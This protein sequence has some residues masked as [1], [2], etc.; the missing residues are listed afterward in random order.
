MNP[1]HKP[2]LFIVDDE[3]DQVFLCELA[4]QRTGDFGRIQ[5]AIDSQ[6]AYQQ[7]LETIDAPERRPD[8][9]LIDWKMP[10]MHGSELAAALSANATL[11]DIPL[12]AMSTSSYAEDR[13]RALEA[14]CKAFHQK[15]GSFD[16]LM[17]LLRQLKAS[18]CPARTSVKG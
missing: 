2:V 1:D 15:P 18:Y 6:M 14:G 16:Q 9:I 11:R 4:A 8:L 17:Q 5:T 7:L 3:P 12:V 13:R 10:R